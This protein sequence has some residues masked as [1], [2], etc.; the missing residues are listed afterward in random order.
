MEKKFGY[1]IKNKHFGSYSWELSYKFLGKKYLTTFSIQCCGSS[2]EKYRSGMG[3]S[4]SGIK[5]P[6]SATLKNSQQL[7]DTFLFLPSAYC[8]LQR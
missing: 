8:T 2:K 4:G 7:L 1:E 5:N 6:R 3:K